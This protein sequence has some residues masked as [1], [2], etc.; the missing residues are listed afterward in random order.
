[1]HF[2]IIFRMLP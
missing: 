2:K 1:M